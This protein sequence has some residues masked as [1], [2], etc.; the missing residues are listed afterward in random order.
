MGDLKPCP[1]CGECVHIT[2]FPAT[3]NR[4]SPYDPADRAFPIV[5][6]QN[7]YTERPGQNFPTPWNSTK[8]AIAAWNRRATPP[9]VTALVDALARAEEALAASLPLTDHPTTDQ[10]FMI[11]RARDA[12]RAALAAWE[13][14]NDR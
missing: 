13:G 3:C 4:D 2:A 9:E 10:A 11:L 14:T 1:F 12:A 5:R 8:S 7:C 6:C